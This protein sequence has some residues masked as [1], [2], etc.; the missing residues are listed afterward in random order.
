MRTLSAYL[1]NVVLAMAAVVAV[2]PSL[3][4]DATID[5]EAT[6]VRLI[7]GGASGT[8]V[9]H[10]KG[11]DHPFTMKAVSVG[12][13]GV[14]AVD[15]TGTVENLTKVEDFA[16][17][18]AGVGIGAAAVKGQGASKFQNEKGVV[19]TTVAKST[20]AALNLGASGVIIEMGK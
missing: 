9:L 6:Q 7:L 1:A 3:A 10:F 12:G 2:Q 16:G 19:V 14:T 15:G 11:K 8:G 4:A 18:Y 5:F 13:A 17:K 20:G